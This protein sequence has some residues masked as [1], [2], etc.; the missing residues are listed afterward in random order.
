MSH[1]VIQFRETMPRLPEPPRNGDGVTA[2]AEILT[3]ELRRAFGGQ[4]FYDLANNSKPAD[5]PPAILS[6]SGSYLAG[7]GSS[8][9]FLT[10]SV[11]AITSG[12]R[13]QN[14]LYRRSGAAQWLLAA[15]IDNTSAVLVRIDDLS[16]GIAFDVAVQEVSPYG[17]LG[18]VVTATASP[19]TT[20]GDTT[21]PADPTAIAV[22][23]S[24]AK[25]VEIDLTF[26]APADWAIT[27]LYRNTANDSGA[28]TLIEIKKA[29]RFHDENVSYGTTYYY[30]AKVVDLSG[31]KSG[32]SPSASHS[33]LVARIVTADI[34][35][36]AITVSGSSKNDGS[37]TI[38]A[39][40]TDLITVDVTVAASEDVYVFAYATI[41]GVSADVRYINVSVYRDTTVLSQ[42]QLAL[43]STPGDAPA[44]PLSMIEIDTPGAGTF[45]YKFRASNGNA[46]CT[47]TFRRIIVLK[48]KK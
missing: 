31:N 18:N 19:F 17:R 45:T 29:K 37:V 15:Q 3:K 13:Y 44:T 1:K 6:T 42:G 30:W 28:A 34:T 20:P 14:V 4:F 23:Q 47:A 32:F 35:D 41:T 43:L 38:A 25:I 36:E 10:M 22:R 7:D 40:I 24:G 5:P 39:T 8:L 2:W 21:A 11:P 12:A 48:R 16:T 27:E 26:T 46:D 33:I 9:A